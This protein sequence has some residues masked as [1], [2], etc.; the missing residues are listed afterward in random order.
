MRVVWVELVLRLGIA[1]KRGLERGVQH[2]L[3][4]PPEDGAE[5]TAVRVTIVEPDTGGNGNT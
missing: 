1:A 4:Q 3:P 2:L 5:A